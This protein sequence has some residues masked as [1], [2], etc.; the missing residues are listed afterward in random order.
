MYARFLAACLFT[1]S[2]VFLL[3]FPFTYQA[4]AQIGNSTL[5]GTVTDASG[6]ASSARS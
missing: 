4:S 5:S 2:L 6:A 3:L 1:G